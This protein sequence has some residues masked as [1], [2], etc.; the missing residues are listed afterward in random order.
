MNFIRLITA[1]FFSVLFFNNSF[2]L[3]ALPS[4]ECTDRTITAAITVQINCDD[5]DT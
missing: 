1:I 3:I 5:N 2:A 4:G